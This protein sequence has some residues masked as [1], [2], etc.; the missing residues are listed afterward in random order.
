MSGAFD[1]L[2][3]LGRGGFDTHATLDLRGLKRDEALA[4]LQALIDTHAAPAPHRYAVLIDPATPGGGETL[5]QPVGRYLLDVKVD[6]LSPH[7]PRNPRSAGET[8]RTT[9]EYLT[10]MR[11]F[12]RVIPVHYQEPFRRDFSKGWQPKV[13]DFATDLR[14]AIK[15][16]AAG[17]CF[18]N[19]DNR[20]GPDAQPGRADHQDGHRRGL[21]LQLE[22]PERRCDQAH[23]KCAPPDSIRPCMLL[24]QGR[25]E[26]NK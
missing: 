6:F 5:F 10:W 15:G 26:H 3:M 17:W 24:P 7:R 2:T 23:F 13:E 1:P 8:A 18:H 25:R 22:V 21:Q 14:G 11:G 12:E 4:K 9:S 19:G 20:W 16:G